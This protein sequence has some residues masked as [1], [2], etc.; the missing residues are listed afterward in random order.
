[1]EIR[2][3]Q[4][5]RLFLYA[6][7]GAVLGASSCSGDAAT[8]LGPTPSASLVGTLSSGVNA[9][10]LNCSPLPYSSSSASIGPAGGV[11]TVGPHV[12]MVPLNAL[13]SRVTITGEVI[14]G[15][16][17][18]VRFSPEGLKF[19]KNAV[20]VM[21]YSNCSG[22]GMLLPKKIAYTSELLSILE[23]IQSVDLAGQKKVT[24]QVKHFSRYAVAY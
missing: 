16:V 15:N 24:G 21:S 12:L 5:P 11:L 8:P 3:M 19:R 9:L 7:A 13:T 4:Q 18:S 22:L 23:L 14:S 1:M 6:L 17:N 2:V 10:L 20:L